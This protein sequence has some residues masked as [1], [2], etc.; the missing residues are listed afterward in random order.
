MY[1]CTSAHTSSDAFNTDLAN[2]EIFHNRTLMI[3]WQA[4]TEYKAG[5]L[6][7]VNGN[8]YRRTSDGYDTTWSTGFWELVTNSIMI[9][10]LMQITQEVSM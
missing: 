2:W 8:L 1:K 3:D 10:V 4:N 5:Q 6:V 9:G 7:V